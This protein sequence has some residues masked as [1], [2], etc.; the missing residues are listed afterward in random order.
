LLNALTVRPRLSKLA[1]DS[2]SD[3]DRPDLWDTMVA[4]LTLKIAVA[5][6]NRIRLR[7]G[8]EKAQNVLRCTPLSHLSRSQHVRKGDPRNRGV[9][10]GVYIKR[11]VYV[12]A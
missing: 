5:D 12:V 3:G 10:L 9:A 8:F 2:H 6:E 4:Q 1:L 11:R 7:D